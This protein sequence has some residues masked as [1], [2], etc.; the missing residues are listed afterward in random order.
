MFHENE[1]LQQ[2]VAEN[3]REPDFYWNISGSF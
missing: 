3:F 2:L 1:K